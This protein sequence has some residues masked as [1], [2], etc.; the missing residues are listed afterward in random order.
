MY[1]L[2]ALYFP[3]SFLKLIDIV[4]CGMTFY[5]TLRLLYQ[6]LDED[7]EGAGDVGG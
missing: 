6:L 7:R 3:P 2:S 1:T 5:W 4:T